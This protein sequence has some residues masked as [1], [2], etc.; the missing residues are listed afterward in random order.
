MEH[1]HQLVEW[2]LHWA[3]TPYGTVALFLVAFA[4]SS[5]FLVPP[6]LLQIALSVLR[7]QESFFF[8]GVS[9]VGSLGGAALGYA[10]GRYGG[11]PLLH[12]F[13]SNER[14]TMVERAFQK[15]DAWAIGIAGFTPVPY[16]IFAI[17]G[18]VF[19][20]NFVKFMCVSAIARGAR[21]FIVASAFHFFGAQ[22]QDVILKNLN[23]FSIAFVILLIG[24][25]IAIKI[26]TKR[27]S[28]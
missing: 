19:R 7:P 25:F 21:F 5:F 23:L 13:F 3:Q 17:S 10:I 1:L 28:A 8:A 16:K 2:T 18:G 22:I 14:I 9:L 4:E 26:F 27:F 20:I 6:D 11:R 24:G 15:H 12:K